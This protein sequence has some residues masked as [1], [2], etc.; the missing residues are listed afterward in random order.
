MFYEWFTTKYNPSMGCFLGCYQS[1]ITPSGG[2][3]NTKYDLMKAGID[4]KRSAGVVPEVILRTLLHTGE[5]SAGVVPEVN[6]RTLLYT[7]DRT[8]GVVPEVILRTLLH[9]GERSAGVVTLIDPLHECEQGRI[10]NFS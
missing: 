10:Q 5:R 9:T 4:V 1:Y 8:A 7:G 3:Y 2:A 6:P